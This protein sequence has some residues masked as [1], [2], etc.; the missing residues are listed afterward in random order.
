VKITYY[1]LKI[2]RKKNMKVPLKM[3]FHQ[4]RVSLNGKTVM[5]MMDPLK[6][7]NQMVMEN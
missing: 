2:A 4:V 6:M 7:E 1:I 3:V 5:F